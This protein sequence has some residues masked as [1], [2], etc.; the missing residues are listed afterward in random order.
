MNCFDHIVT[1]YSTPINCWFLFL[2]SLSAQIVKIISFLSLFFLNLYFFIMPALIFTSMPI[3]SLFFWFLVNKTF[4]K[5]ICL[6]RAIFEYWLP[7]YQTEFSVL[8]APSFWYGCSDRF[9][10]ASLQSHFLEAQYPCYAPISMFTLSD[11]TLRWHLWVL[12][13]RFPSF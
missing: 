11:Y 8:K 2:V 4:L 5:F 6:S 13:A 10:H 7:N 9:H 3:N 1:V 12:S